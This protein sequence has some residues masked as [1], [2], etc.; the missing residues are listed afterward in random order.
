[1]SILL[2]KP[3]E[4]VVSAIAEK[5]FYIVLPIIFTWFGLMKFTSYEAAAIEGL[6]ANS[7]FV[8]FLLPLL[9][10]QGASNLIGAVELVVAV[11][12]LLR[13]IDPLL[14]FIGAILATAT[15]IVTSTF[16]FTTP[17]VFLPDV[18]GLA[19]SVVP[20]QFLLKD[21]G[22]LVASIWVLNES[23]NAIKK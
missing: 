1:M 10:Q 8:S 21:L 18:G 20:G 2:P 11:L 16:F 6:I 7:P 12:I 23:A 4:T 19:V 9:G 14:S 3:V 22:L 5:G 17:G 15:F 13:F